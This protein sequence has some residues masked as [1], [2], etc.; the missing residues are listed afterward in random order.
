MEVGAS[1]NVRV[2]SIQ[3]GCEVHM[4]ALK[5]LQDLGKVKKK[6]LAYCS[7]QC[8]QGFGEAGTRAE[9]QKGL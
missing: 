6:M 1:D 4:S 9:S 2:N 5:T 3:T 7:D 8:K